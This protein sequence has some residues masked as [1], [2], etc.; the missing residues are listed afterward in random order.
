MI[1]ATIGCLATAYCA[2]LHFERRFGGVTGRQMG[3][4]IEISETVALAICAM[5]AARLG[6]S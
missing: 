3:A 2:S 5:S 1:L 4:V 6:L